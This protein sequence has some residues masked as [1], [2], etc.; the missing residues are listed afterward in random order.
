[1]QSP[2]SVQ[3]N[4]PSLHVAEAPSLQ[5][6]PC[7]TIRQSEAHGEEMT[8]PRPRGKSVAEPMKQPPASPVDPGGLSNA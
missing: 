8:S 5:L 1:M 3:L 4:K 7:F 2:S 6:C